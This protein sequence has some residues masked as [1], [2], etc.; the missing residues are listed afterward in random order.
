MATFGMY[1]GKRLGA[2][3][4]LALAAALGL[5]ACGGAG[6]T[7]GGLY[8]GGAGGSSSAAAGSTSSSGGSVNLQCASGAVVCTKTVTVSGKSVTALADTKGMTLYY[9]TPDSA[10]SVTCTGSCA[11]TWPP[12]AASG[13]MSGANLSGM[14]TTVSGANGSQLEYNGHPLYRYAADA[15]PSD[16]K[17]EGIFGKWFVATN[18][19]AGAAAP[20]SASPTTAPSNGYGA[21]GY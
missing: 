13:S 7:G 8:G 5:A 10:S 15:S 11:Q 16:V 14:L 4:G 3:A 18:D 2:F 20:A 21:G 6:A 19:L 17:G 9:F 1:K 12:L